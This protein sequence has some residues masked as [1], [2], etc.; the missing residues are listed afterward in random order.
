MLTLSRPLKVAVLCSHRAPG[1]L[2]LLN[3]DRERGRLFEV[4]CCVTSER[5][6]DEEV[7]VERRG[8]PTLSHSIEDF[9]A[10]ARRAG[11]RRSRRSLRVRRRRRWRCS[12][13]M[14]QTWCVLDGYLYLVTEPLLSAFRAR[15]I[16]LHFADLTERTRRVAPR[17]PGSAPSA[18][19]W[20]PA[21]PKRGRPSTW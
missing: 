21:A 9:Y 6:F 8:V 2:Y 5:T 20:R 11:L 7:R 4:V 1:L 17:F 15:V 19:R 16:N 3:R 12:S 14:R 18:T 10:L 13:H